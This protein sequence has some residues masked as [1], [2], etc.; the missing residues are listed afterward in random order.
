MKLFDNNGHN[1]PEHSEK[2]EEHRFTEKIRQYWRNMFTSSK[3]KNM[4]HGSYYIMRSMGWPHG[5]ECRK[6]HLKSLNKKH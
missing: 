6:N 2:K 3:C 5:E 1:H 4:T